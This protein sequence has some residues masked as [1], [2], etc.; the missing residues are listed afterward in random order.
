VIS[1]RGE[2][3]NYFGEDDFVYF[4]PRFEELLGYEDHEFPDDLK[5]WPGVIHP[6]DLKL[7]KQAVIDHFEHRNPYEV[8]YRAR[9]KSGEYRWFR[10]RGQALWDES[11]RPTRIMGFMS[12]VTNQKSLEA[13]LLS[14]KKWTPLDSWRAVSPTILTTCSPS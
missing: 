14:P 9:T 3:G 1:Y 6:D 13:Q 11:G 5:K 8:E 10:E 12:D 7:V 4:S 2:D